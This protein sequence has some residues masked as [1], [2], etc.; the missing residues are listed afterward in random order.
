MILDG[1]T[2]AKENE[3][4]LRL[5]VEKLKE[6]YGK[7]PTLATILV[8]DNPASITYVRMKENACKRV[9]IDSIHI[10]L[11]NDIS[12][13]ELVKKIKELCMFFVFLY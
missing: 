9:G 7:V 1:K 8:G 6:E 2:L 13:E 4:K 5:E 10:E 11:S 3:E 12:E